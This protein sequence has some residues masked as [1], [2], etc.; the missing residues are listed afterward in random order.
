MKTYDTIIV[1]GGITGVSLAFW[2]NKIFPKK[3]ILLIEERDS[4]AAAATGRNGGFLTCGSVQFFG[5]LVEE[6]GLERAL[7]IWHFCEDNRRLIQE[8]VLQGV[9]S[10]EYDRK[11]AYTLLTQK[12]SFE[13]AASTESLM[14]AS[15]LDVELI[16]SK[17]IEEK[18]KLKNFQGGVYYGGDGSIRSKDLVHHIASLLNAE[19]ILNHKV[20]A[21]DTKEHMVTVKTSKDV[22]Q[23]G[24]VILAVNPYS[25]K[26]LPE[27]TEQVWP[28]RAQICETEV[29]PQFL[30][31]NIYSSDE[32]VYFRQMRSGAILLGGKRLIDNEK[33]HT[34]AE[35]LND[36]IQNALGDY[37]S[38]HISNNIKIVKRWAGIMGFCKDDVP[39]IGE[40]SV[41]K[42]V[43]YLAGY[44]G[45]GMGM[46]FKSSQKL[47]LWL[48]GKDELGILDKSSPKR[49]R[50]DEKRSLYA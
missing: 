7:E 4:L 15:G 28:I 12:N 41:H 5:K 33:E 34:D 39:F 50:L 36:F 30:A 21:F 9:F 10:F 31:G 35:D 14:R 27:L 42:N 25:R 8:N 38:K 32:L 49:Y 6:R 44:S 2:H 16:S 48:A 26:L 18:L 23:A 29:V 3:K 11:G 47:T 24:Q 40:S 45:H 46:A 13:K 20:L 17:Q 22:F 19:I 37:L 43:F 1:G